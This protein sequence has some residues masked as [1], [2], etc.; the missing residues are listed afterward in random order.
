MFHSNYISKIA[1][2]INQSQSIKT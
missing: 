2:A 1:V